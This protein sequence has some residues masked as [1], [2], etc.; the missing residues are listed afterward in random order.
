[1]S[2]AATAHANHHRTIPRAKAAA[3]ALLLAVVAVVAL[4]FASPDGHSTGGRPTVS[5]HEQPVQNGNHE[6]L[7]FGRVR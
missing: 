7:W 4:A 5:R 6:R 3:I 1:M 2:K